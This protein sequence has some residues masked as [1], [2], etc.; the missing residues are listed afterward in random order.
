MYVFVPWLQDL[1]SLSHFGGFLFYPYS[2]FSA[3]SAQYFI[4]PVRSRVDFRPYVSVH[5]RDYVTSPM[6]SSSVSPVGGGGLQNLASDL[7]MLP[8]TDQKLD[9]A[10]TDCS[11]DESKREWKY[12]FESTY[13]CLKVSLHVSWEWL[14]TYYT[15]K[16]ACW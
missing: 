4:P 10:E 7:L 1:V 12:W 15:M 8:K 3:P 14:L 2:S 9:D 6:I 16:L 5:G 13:C 11:Q